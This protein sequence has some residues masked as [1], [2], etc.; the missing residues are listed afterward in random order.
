[1]KTSTR[2]L[3]RHVLT[4]VLAFTGMIESCAMQPMAPHPWP[5]SDWEPAS[6]EEV[7]MDMAL[8]EQARD[9][10]LTGGGSGVIIRYGR[11]VF[12]WG[13]Q[14]QRYDLKSTTKSF[15][16]TALGIALLDGRVTIED[17]V[18]TCHPTFGVPPEENAAT[19]WLEQITL[20][21]LVTHTSGFG[22][23]GGYEPLLFE[24]GTRFLY[25]DSAVNWL[26]ECLTLVYKRDMMEL[27]F[28]RIFTPIGISREDLSWRTNQYRPAEIEGVP[29]REFASG[30]HANVNAMARLG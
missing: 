20:L 27:M 21:H 30:I 26:A 19:G 28:E 29:R 6:S 7:D 2:Y 8:L 22:Y 23:P 24:P 18:S 15:G 3:T 1:M 5:I 25:S 13:D 14:E 4:V 10:A 9:Y 17:P 16:V 11:Q 12:S